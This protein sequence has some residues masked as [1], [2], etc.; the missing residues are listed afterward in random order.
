M[1]MKK[2][3]SLDDYLNWVD[4]QSKSLT[5]PSK[6][7]HDLRSLDYALGKVMYGE[8]TTQTL[9]RMDWLS[10][11][12]KEEYKKLQGRDV[13]VNFPTFLSTTDDPN[14]KFGSGAP[15][16][17][18]IRTQFIIQM[19]RIRIAPIKQFSHFFTEKEVLLRPNA[20]MMIESAEEKT[21]THG[22]KICII[23]LRSVRRNSKQ[24]AVHHTF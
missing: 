1:G 21:A 5:V 17:G 14:F 19:D 16:A 11:V 10:P 20:Q 24:I 2:G 22:G 4:P 6:M 15:T 9:Y 12:K 8:P 18:M 3:V 13:C 7:H 23:K